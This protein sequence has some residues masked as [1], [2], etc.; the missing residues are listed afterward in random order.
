[1]CGE[2]LPRVLDSSEETVVLKDPPKVH[3]GFPHDLGTRL[4]AAMESLR[5]TSVVVV[6]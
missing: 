1:M 4:A 6:K 2:I 5:N 3:G